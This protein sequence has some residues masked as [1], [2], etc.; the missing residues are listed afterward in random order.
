MM[1]NIVEITIGKKKLGFKFGMLTLQMFS[2]HTGVEFGEI[3]DHLESRPIDSIVILFMAANTVY[4]EG[5]N[6]SV[7]KF[8]VD[9]WI[10]QMSDEDYQSIMDC[11]SRTM[12]QIITKL[13]APGPEKAKKK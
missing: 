8:M 9:D 4:S 3:I 11:W 12:E 10:S 13:N 7:S 2:D 1:N 5:K 6:G